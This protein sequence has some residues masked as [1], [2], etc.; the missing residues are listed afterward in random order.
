MSECAGHAEKKRT[1]MNED[2]NMRTIMISY[3]CKMA[4][5]LGMDLGLFPCGEVV[6]PV[7][8]EDWVQMIRRM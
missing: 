1:Q 5:N 6:M 4:A 3:S 7:R 8:V 2:A